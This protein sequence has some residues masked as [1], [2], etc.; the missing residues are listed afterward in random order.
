MPTR[1]AYDVAI[2]GAGLAGLTLARQLLLYSDKTVLL[3]DKRPK[4]P[5][6][7][8]KVGEST[9]QVGAYYYSKVLDL[10]E[11]LLHEQ[12]MKYNLRFYWKAGRDNARFEDYGQSYIRTF[13]NIACYQL[14]RNTFEA[15]LLRRNVAESRLTFCPGPADLEVGLRPGGPHAVRFSVGGARH[16]LRAGWVVDAT[17]RGKFLARRLGL[18]KENPIRHGASFLWVDGLVDIDK[19]TDRSPAEIR[20]KRERSKIGHS[21]FWLATNH[22]MGEGLWFWVIP[23]RH[24]T[25]LGLVYDTRLVPRERVNSAAKLLRWACEEFPLFARDLPSRKV[26]DYNAL[27]D[28]SYDC[29]QTVSAER[30]ALAGEAGRFTDPLYSPG[31]DLIALHNTLITDA[32]LTDDAGELAAKC[33]LFE[34]LMRAFYQGTVPS[35]AVSY[36]ALG[37]QEAFTLKYVWE[38]SVYFP[39]HVFPFVNGLFPNPHFIAPYLSRLARLGPLNRDLQQFISDFYQ[40]K[41]QERQP[42]RRPLFND[43]TDV[44]PL[45]AAE[46]SFYCVGASPEEGC[47]LLDTHLANLAELARFVVAHV[48]SAVVGDRRALTNAPF[49]TEIDLADVRFD[50]AAIRERYRRHA[51][52]AETYAWSFDPF[53]LDLFRADAPAEAP[54]P[55]LAP[56]AQEACRA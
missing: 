48:S 53:V 13:S 19:L 50:P 44:A 4:V 34:P 49:V 41:K 46:R 29:A 28:F 27:K 32:I 5:S 1:G 25:S 14:D 17:G 54:A 3:L 47:R 8:Q 6:P 37:D 55:L 36:D 10:E 40:W 39:F 38:L 56:L 43:F 20:L 9:V 24:K 23:L 31:S 42:P 35:Y 7:R 11:Y 33:R 22:F 12:L 51:G 45:R 16:D 15:E 30:W 26:L 2:L 21:P 52:A 18:A